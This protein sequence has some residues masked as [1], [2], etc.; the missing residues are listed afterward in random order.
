MT[1]LLRN[2]K[3][4]DWEKSFHAERKN[5]MV[6][7]LYDQSDQIF[8]TNIQDLNLWDYLFTKYAN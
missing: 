7:K 1:D 2:D 3:F 4:V 5:E 6:G 8:K